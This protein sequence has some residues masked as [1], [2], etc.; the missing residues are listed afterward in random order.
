MKKFLLLISLFVVVKF[1]KAQCKL[2]PIDSLQTI[3]F[4]PNY[5]ANDTS[6]YLFL[7]GECHGVSSNPIIESTFLQY[8][9][10]NYNVETILLESGYTDSYLINKYLQT[11]D[12]VF[13]NL[14]VSDYP[15]KYAECKTSLISI[16]SYYDRLPA[17]KKFKMISFDIVEND[18]VPY[19]KKLFKILLSNEIINNNLK[20]EMEQIVATDSF[21]NNMH[22]IKNILSNYAAKV[23]YNSCFETIVNSYIYWLA[24]KQSLF[25]NREV[26]LYK[27][28]LKIRNQFAGN[29][30]GHFGYGHIDLNENTG[31]MASY[32]KNEP[33]FKNKIISIHPY[34]YNCQSSFFNLGKSEGYN[35]S[36][37]KHSL[38]KLA[39]QKGIYITSQKNQFYIIHVGYKEM[40]EL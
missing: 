11:D 28:I 7:T 30:Y 20:K 13:L 12:S 16:K 36:Y 26:Y 2:I 8:L 22:I 1:L 3:N 37:F 9:S 31:S 29:I 23:D 33:S 32:L 39:L 40:M 21:P 24:N 18:R 4:F 10:T 17:D 15:Q 5:S 6:G 19:S 25:K 27:N 14:Y 38:K 34:Y 35:K